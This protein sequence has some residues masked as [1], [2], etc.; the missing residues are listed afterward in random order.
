VG[1]VFAVVYDEWGGFFDHV[2]PPEV[3]DSRASH[4]PGQDFGQTGFRV[5]AIVASPFV[6]RGYADHRMYDHTS[7]LRMAEWRF[8]GAPADGPGAG[9]HGRWWLTDRGRHSHNLAA[10]LVIDADPDVGF[11]LDL[12][13]PPGADPCTFGA[14]GGAA[15]G[16]PFQNTSQAMADL[17]NTRFP[18]ASEKAWSH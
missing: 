15:H 18:E 17:Q 6:R 5:P 12:E 2:H 1:D 9:A 14:L 10:S 11:D 13:L 16:D 3:P 7:L 8:L 4:V